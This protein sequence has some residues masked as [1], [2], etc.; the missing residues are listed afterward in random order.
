MG[1]G[2]EKADLAFGGLNK[3]WENN[4]RYHLIKRKGTA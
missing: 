4:G 3:E 2:E 1:E